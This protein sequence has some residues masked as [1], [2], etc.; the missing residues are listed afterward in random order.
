MKKDEKPNGIYSQLFIITARKPLVYNNDTVYGLSI[1]VNTKINKILKEVEKYIWDLF[2]DD[3][4]K[5]NDLSPLLLVPSQE[6]VLLKLEERDLNDITYSIEF[7]KD[8][9]Q[10]HIAMNELN[11]EVPLT[12]TVA[13][14]KKEFY[15]LL[16]NQLHFQYQDN[17]PCQTEIQHVK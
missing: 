13:I 17:L 12:K 11:G 7:Y 6:S 14:D 1:V 8:V 3:E 10:D 15:E 9:Y 2:I 5:P 4:F 16:N